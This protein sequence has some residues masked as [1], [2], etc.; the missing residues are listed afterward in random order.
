MLDEN[1][2]KFVAVGINVFVGSVCL[3]GVDY[4]YDKEIK[5]LT[6]Q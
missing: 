5:W 3:G 1:V 4:L 2:W 6:L